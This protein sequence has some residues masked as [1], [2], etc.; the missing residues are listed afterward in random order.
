MAGTPE[1]DARKLWR[2]DVIER[3]RAQADSFTWAVPGIAIA[4]Q[5]FLLSIALN[6]STEPL[7]R[8]IAAAAGLSAVLALGHLLFKQV[9]LFDLYEALIERERRSY[10]LNLPGV[11]YRML[12]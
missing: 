9:Y 8:L 11:G 2:L 5:A 7:G 4:A 3:R 6:A 1:P 10:D 12:E